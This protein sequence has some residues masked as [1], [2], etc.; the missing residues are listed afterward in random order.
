M[1]G[2]HVSVTLTVCHDGQFWVGASTKAQQALSCQLEVTKEDRKASAR[3]RREEDRRGWL[4]RRTQKRKR[5]YRG[6]RTT[7]KAPKRAPH[8]WG[9]ERGPM[10]H[11]LWLQRFL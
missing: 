11:A 1:Q 5:R 6:H 4:G 9:A 3:E 7:P 2:S 10:P 8:P